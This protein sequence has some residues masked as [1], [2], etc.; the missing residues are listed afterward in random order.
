MWTKYI[1]FVKIFT[2]LKR[3]ISFI[4]KELIIFLSVDKSLKKEV[5]FENKTLI[6]NVQVLQKICQWTDKLTMKVSNIS[7]AS[8]RKQYAQILLVS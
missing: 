5:Y 8:Y 3:F 6:Y 4:L 2:V 7:K 1:L